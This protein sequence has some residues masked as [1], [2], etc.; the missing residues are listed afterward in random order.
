M[1]SSKISSSPISG[2]VYI[3]S[4]SSLRYCFISKIL[5][6]KASPLSPCP[7]PIFFPLGV[8]ITSNLPGGTIFIVS[9]EKIFFAVVSIF[10]GLGVKLAY[11]VSEHKVLYKL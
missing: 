11:V 5:A 1:W 2:V 7:S 8:I 9:D 10:S 4:T 3:N 6:F